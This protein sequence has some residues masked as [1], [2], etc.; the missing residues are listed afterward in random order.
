MILLAGSQ[1]TVEK[2]QSEVLNLLEDFKNEESDLVKNTK[3]EN[4]A[5]TTF[6]TADVVAPEHWQHYKGSLRNISEYKG[7]LVEVGQSTFDAVSQLVSKS[8][9]ES[10]VGLGMD[11]LNLHH[12]KIQ[13]RK[14]YQVENV[15]L[16]KRYAT[17]LKEF[18]LMKSG[19]AIPSIQDLQLHGEKGVET[20]GRFI[21]YNTKCHRLVDSHP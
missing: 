11:A 3:E 13:V 4:E 10:L 15:A 6:G 7:H 16:Y 9:Q 21:S 19:E 1:E 2:S 8:W 12:R 5:M 20:L 18:C 14:V 17:K